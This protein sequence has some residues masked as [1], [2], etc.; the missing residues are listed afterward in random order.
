M[1]VCY[2]FNR[3]D[4]YTEAGT[5]KSKGFFFLFIYFKTSPF[6]IISHCICDHLV[7]GNKCW[8]NAKKTSTCCHWWMLS[9]AEKQKINGPYWILIGR[10]VMTSQHSPHLGF[11][12]NDLLAWLSWRWIHAKHFWF[13]SQ[14]YTQTHYGAAQNKYA[15]NYKSV[16]SWLLCEWSTPPYSL[17][18]LIHNSTDL[19]KGNKKVFNDFRSRSSQRS[20]FRNSAFRNWFPCKQRGNDFELLPQTLPMQRILGEREIR[21][22]TLLAFR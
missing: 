13:I 20:A 1:S 15:S 2:S 19:Q 16:L 14:N 10:S 7:R 12:S 9:G 22:I 11:N 18:V 17:S 4:I 21:I 5:L 3:N 6:Q 8:C